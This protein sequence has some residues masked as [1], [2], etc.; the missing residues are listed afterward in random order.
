MNIGL[1]YT[2]IDFETATP[3]RDSPCELG[4]CMVENGRVVTVKS[5]LIKPIYYPDFSPMNVSVHGIKPADVKNAPS[6]AQLW[7]EILPFIEGKLLVAH[8]SAFDISVLVRTLQLYSINIPEFDYLCTLKL[9][10]G[11][12]TDKSSYKLN[13]LCGDLGIQFNHHKAEED[14][15]VTA[16]LFD[17]IV[18]NSGVNSQEELKER[19][20][21]GIRKVSDFGKKERSSVRRIKIDRSNID[22]SKDLVRSD[23]LSGLKIVIS[24]IFQRYSRSEI[25]EVILVNGG[26]NVSSISKSTDF[27]VAGDSMGPAKKEKAEKLGVRMITEDEFVGML[28]R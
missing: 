21:T 28:N 7:P 14:C 22:L 3:K 23:K 5:W 20:G 1:S 4:V 16:L 18:H 15:R 6:F 24:G 25:K 26:K 12:W 13:H 10:K 27:I 9:A 17:H 19:F 8:N 2:V 11:F